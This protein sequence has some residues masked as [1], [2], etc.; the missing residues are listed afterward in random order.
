M[1]NILAIMFLLLQFSYVNAAEIKKRAIV[2][3]ENFN[4]NIEEIELKN[5]TSSDSYE[6][7][8]F[9]IVNGKNNQA[10]RF[11]DSEDLQLRAATTYYHMNKAR[12]FFTDVVKSQY[13]Q[14]LPQITIRLNLSN[15]FNEVGHFA[16]DNLDPQFNNALTIPA[17]LGYGP[18]NIEPWG[19]EVWF[20]PSK[21]INIKNLNDVDNYGDSVKKSLT[22]FR[23][24]TQMANLETF[25][26]RILQSITGG[27]F[28]VNSVMRLVGSSVIIESIYQSSGLAAEFFARKIYHLDAA[29]VPEIIY[30]EFS[31]VALSDH[32]E[33]SHSTP[34]NEGLA[35]YFAGKIANSKNLATKIKEY[36][37][38]NGKKVKKKQQYQMAFE[39]GEYA[40]TDFVFGLLWNVGEVVGVDIETKF[41]YH[42]SAFITTNDSIRNELI[43][44]TLKT[45]KEICKAPLNDQI[46]LYKLYNSK[47]L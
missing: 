21:E 44:A 2:R 37:L 3:D 32:L 33:L 22:N 11:D 29:L 42:L 35:D 6:G 46:K 38:F 1:K 30:H 4:A 43:D 8:Y 24:Q 9:K 10:I 25:I 19:I 39:R 47:N 13:V 14:A 7:K 5:L 15:V 40:N 26:T 12:L 36:N 31:H 41:I 20:R 45:C 34:I 28:P 23:N 18:K 27:A 16:N 17:G